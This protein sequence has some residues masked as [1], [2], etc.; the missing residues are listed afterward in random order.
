MD[1]GRHAHLGLEKASET[2]QCLLHLAPPVLAH[3]RRWHDSGLR[4][5]VGKESYVLDAN[6]QLFVY[7]WGFC[8]STSRIAEAAWQEYKRDPRA[9]ERVITQH[10]DGGY[11]TMYRL[12]M[13]GRHGAFDP[14]YGYYLIERDAPDARI[15]DWSEL[16]GKFE[17][18]RG[19]RHRVGP[20]FEIAGIEWERALL[21][22][23]A[24]FES[25]AV[26][27]AAGAPKENVFGD[28]AYKMGTPLH[29]MTFA[30]QRGMTIER[31][32]QLRAQVLRPAARSPSASGPSCRPAGST[33]SP[34]PRTA[35]VGRRTI[36]TTSA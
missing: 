17:I 20:F 4:G 13:D 6:K 32:G 36:P 19:Y 30:M 9:A 7:G 3:G 21:L 11:H 2:A 26:W 23:P 31:L 33:G 34:K 12:R 8:G 22:R 28:G 27:R 18:N 35:A 24:Y 10:D 25:E 1:L 16:T 15:L 14:R 5:V 29:D